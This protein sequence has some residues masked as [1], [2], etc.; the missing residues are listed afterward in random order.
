LVISQNKKA[1]LPIEWIGEINELIEIPESKHEKA[2]T[3]VKRSYL[4]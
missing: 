1:F 2:T 3:A 4:W